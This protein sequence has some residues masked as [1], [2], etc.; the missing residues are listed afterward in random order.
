[1]CLNV[2]EFITYKVQQFDHFTFIL[3]DPQ[4]EQQGLRRFWKKCIGIFLLCYKKLKKQNTTLI[5]NLPCKS[6]PD[7]LLSAWSQREHK[8]R[9]V[10][11]NTERDAGGMREGLPGHP[12][13]VIPF[14]DFSVNG[15][16]HC[17]IQ[18]FNLFSPF[19]FFKQPWVFHC[20]GPAL[21]YQQQGYTVPGDRLEGFRFEQQN[22]AGLSFKHL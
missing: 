7:C 21:C 2:F 5:P 12:S 9:A 22:P 14:A 1:M 17:P 19:S 4:K 3:S 8:S 11:R 15:S 18:V 20:L 10:K 16:C 6:F 13:L